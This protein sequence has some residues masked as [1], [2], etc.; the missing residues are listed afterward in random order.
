V[1][2]KRDECGCHKEC[3]TYPHSCQNPCIWPKYLTK[4][5]QQELVDEIMNDELLG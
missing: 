1:K 3:V 5:E 2:D 4:A